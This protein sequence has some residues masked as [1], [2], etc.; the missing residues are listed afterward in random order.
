MLFEAEPN[1]SMRTLG[2]WTVE[3][4]WDVNLAVAVLENDATTVSLKRL[5][6]GE[7]A[8]EAIGYVSNGCLFFD[9]HL[10][11]IFF[12]HKNVMNL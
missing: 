7:D 10:F 4:N 12:K 3:K 6:K 8:T 9:E 5:F 1:A 11:V 2:G